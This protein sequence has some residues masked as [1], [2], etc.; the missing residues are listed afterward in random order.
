MK[1]PYLILT[2]LLISILGSCTGSGDKADGYGNFEA[3]EITISAEANGKRFFMD[4]EEGN[5]LAQIK[6]VGVID[7]RT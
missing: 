2:S 5:S 1:H 3:T 4:A 7:T 6:V